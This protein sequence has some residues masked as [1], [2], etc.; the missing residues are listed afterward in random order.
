MKRVSNSFVLQAKARHGTDGQGEESVYIR[1]KGDVA[2][3]IADGENPFVC[4]DSNGKTSDDDGYLPSA[5]LQSGIVESNA[6][7]DSD[8]GSIMGT[9]DE[10]GECTAQPKGTSETWPYEWEAKRGKAAANAQGVRAWNEYEGTMKLHGRWARDAEVFSLRVDTP[11]VHWESGFAGNNSFKPA[12]YELCLYKVVGSTNSKLTA[13]P[14]GMSLYYYAYNADG[15]LADSGDSALGTLQS[16]SEFVYT[17]VC[18]YV[19]YVLYSAA[20]AN[21]TELDR[22]RVTSIR[23]YQRMLVPAGVW[24]AAKTYTRTD[25]TVP[26]VFYAPTGTYYYL[27]ADSAQ[28]AAGNNVPSDSA[29]CYWKAVPEYEV[30]LVRML[31][32]EFARLGSF[33]V[34]ERFFFSQYGT[35]I[36]AT[37]VETNINAYRAGASYSQTLYEL[38]G[39]G[40]DGGRIIYRVAFTVSAETTIGIGI[41]ASCEEEYDVGA[42]GELDSTALATTSINDLQ[43]GTNCL[44]VDGVTMYASETERKGVRLKVSAGTHFFYII[45]AKD[46]SDD[47]N[48]DKA[49]FAFSGATFSIS[50]VSASEDMTLTTVTKTSVA[51]G[52]FDAADPMAASAP[53]IGYKFRPAKCINALTGEEWAA[54]GKVHFLPDGS[55]ELASGNICWDE[56]GN[57]SFIT[58]GST[59]KISIHDGRIDFFGLLGFPNLTIG[60]DD[61]GCAIIRIFDENNRE[62]YNLGP[63]GLEGIANS[64]NSEEMEMHLGFY[65]IVNNTTLGNVFSANSYDN[66][67]FK[68]GSLEETSVLRRYKAARAAGVIL[69]GNI[70][71]TQA[72]A[73]NA[74]GKYYIYDGTGTPT[75]ANCI[76][77][78]AS[79]G[80]RV[81]GVYYETTDFY[82]VVNGIPEDYSDY[83]ANYAAINRSVDWTYSGTSYN[84]GKLYVDVYKIENGVIAETLSVFKDC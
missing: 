25:R 33:I 37:G 1:T 63:G 8:W 69:A 45:Y 13:V 4:T 48:D 60:T 65:R 38:K 29:T 9:W 23:D 30:V 34:Y 79:Y 42:V 35:L 73:Q 19:E 71:T 61:L 57:T 84:R 20:N 27:D 22:V 70:F 15:T 72:A 49:T 83:S 46:G 55:G 50:E 77:C 39:N 11:T 78:H 58:K 59:N 53:S 81:N 54:G 41:E 68:S 21:G 44:T 74:D 36:S 80:T 18:A 52:W 2:P 6:F 32:A 51:Y 40:A 24:D 16:G 75:L 17:G 31:F 67:L 62:M 5:G 66:V 3:H 14:S 26:L 10:I 47:E 76:V 64:S 43:G 28:G 82:N 7:E 12:S 56:D